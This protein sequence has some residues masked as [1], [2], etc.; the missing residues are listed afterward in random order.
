MTDSPPTGHLAAACSYAKELGAARQAFGLVLGGESSVAINDCG[1]WAL[2]G[3][4]KGVRFDGSLDGGPKFGDC[5]AYEDWQSWTAETKQGF[6]KLQLA[7]MA[8]MCARR[9]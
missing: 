1:C 4:G 8:A 5:R 2:N 9:M 3:V 6:Q 7:W